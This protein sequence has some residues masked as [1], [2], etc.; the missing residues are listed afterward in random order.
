[1]YRVWVRLRKE[2]G[3]AGGSKFIEVL[4]EDGY[5]ALGVAQICKPHLVRKET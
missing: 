5:D 4:R 1:M 2:E 3:V